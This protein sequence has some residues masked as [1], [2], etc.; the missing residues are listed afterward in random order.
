M[1]LLLQER[2]VPWQ[3]L[4]MI[5]TKKTAEEIRERILE[6]GCDR[7]YSKPLGDQ[8]VLL[9]DLQDLKK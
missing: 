4:A 3:I 5:F 1:A 6:A 9:K 2:V 7:Y 8:T